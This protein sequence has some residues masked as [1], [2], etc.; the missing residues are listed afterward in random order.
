[1]VLKSGRGHTRE[2]IPAWDSHAKPPRGHTPK[3][4]E[5]KK[6]DPRD[7]TQ[8]SVKHWFQQEAQLFMGLFPVMHTHSCVSC[9]T[10]SLWFTFVHS[11]V[12]IV[13]Q[14]LLC[15]LLHRLTS[16]SCCT[17]SL[18]FT[19]AQ[20]LVLTVAQTHLCFLCTD[21]LVFIVADSLV[22]YCCTDSLGFIVIHSLMFTVTQT[23]LYLVL[24]TYC[25]YYYTDS[26][27]YCY[28]DP[29]VCFLLHTRGVPYCTD[30]C[31]EPVSSVAS[32]PRGHWFTFLYNTVNL[33]TYSESGV[34]NRTTLMK[35]L[36]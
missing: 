25:V 13:A 15:F 17:Y 8:L 31:E 21:S 6:E 11:L 10:D 33:T 36:F 12:F 32:L 26:R 14:T 34:N 4:S 22:F 16:V 29:H 30:S 9:C 18:V 24:H 2:D 20:T 28:K 7:E 27:V 3:V 1:M 19:V 35:E 5:K 23:H